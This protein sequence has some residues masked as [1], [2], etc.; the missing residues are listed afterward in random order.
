MSRRPKWQTNRPVAGNYLNNYRKKSK[1]SNEIYESICNMEESKNT[2]GDEFIKVVGGAICPSEENKN[3][4]T[5]NNL[6]SDIEK[7]EPVNLDKNETIGF[8]PHQ[9]NDPHNMHRTVKE[10]VLEYRSIT[11]NDEPMDIEDEG[12]MWLSHHATNFYKNIYE[13]ENWFKLGYGDRYKSH[14]EEEE[15]MD[16][17]R[18]EPVWIQFG[19]NIHRCR[20]D[21]SMLKYYQKSIL[22]KEEPMDIDETESEGFH[23]QAS[24][25]QQNFQELDEIFGYRFNKHHEYENLERERKNLEPKSAQVSELTV[26]IPEDAEESDDSNACDCDLDFWL[27]YMDYFY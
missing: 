8:R 16:I 6:K 2:N 5:W 21:S 24:S 19:D 13:P 25:I 22:E 9:I 20:Q 11:E 17:D 1:T 27:N 12:Q 7:G 26:S 10:N 18:N 14:S 15:L 4:S 23:H 3:I